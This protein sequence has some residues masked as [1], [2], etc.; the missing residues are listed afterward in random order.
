MSDKLI[1]RNL[2]RMAVF[3][4][5]VELGSFSKAAAA[6]GLGKSIVSQHVLTLEQALGVL[7]INRSPRSFS[8]TQEGQRFHDACL[9][10]LGAAE[11]AVD[12]LQESK[13]T[14]AGAIRMS[15]PYDFGINFLIGELGTFVEKFPKVTIDLV[16]DD[17]I[18]NMIEDG[19]DLCIRV[20]WLK[21]TNLVAAK[22]AQFRMIPCVSHDFAAK[23]GRIRDPADLA[24]LRWVTITALPH[25]DRV[26]LHNKDGQRRSVRLPFAISTNTGL[27]AREF[28]LRSRLA[29][30]LPDYAVLDELASGRMVRLLPDWTTRDGA[31]Y[32]V[33]QNR[34]RLTPRLRLLVD[35]LRQAA[36]AAFRPEP[37]ADAA[38]A[39]AT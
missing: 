28:V 12:A 27:A 34:D 16:L 13:A 15:A 7:L 8:L 36:R 24:A 39:H 38:L 17:A 3:A 19:F 18:S 29:G 31:I 22:L 26:D 11:A 1:I 37:T 21:Q 35:H 4:K 33:F 6:L 30:L 25:P 9:E 32:A 5:V 23:L 14:A 20:G 2:Y 10:M